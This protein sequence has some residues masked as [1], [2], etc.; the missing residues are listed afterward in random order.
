[1]AAISLTAHMTQT[2]RRGKLSRQSSA[3]FLPVT[4]PSR[5]ESAWN[6]IAI[7]LAQSTTQSSV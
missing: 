4:M 2:V 7:R 6:S 1:M 3:R 5:A